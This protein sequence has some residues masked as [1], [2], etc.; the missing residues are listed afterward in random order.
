[1][2]NELLSNSMEQ[3]PSLECS[4]SS[5]E[6]ASVLWNQKVHYHVHK[7]PLRAPV[8][9]QISAVCTILAYFS[10]INFNVI[11]FYIWVLK[12]IYFF[13]GLPTK[14]LYAFIFSPEHLKC[15]AHVISV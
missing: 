1:M 9:S 10:E 15:Y 12:V 11:R 5:R 2:R 14:A 7:S 8:L 4:S 3:S 6:I 13:P